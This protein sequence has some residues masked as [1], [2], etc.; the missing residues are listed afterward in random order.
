MLRSPG[1]RRWFIALFIL[2]L[3]LAWDGISIPWGWL[4]QT[5]TDWGVTIPVS[6]ARFNPNSTKPALFIVICKL[7]ICFLIVKFIDSTLQARVSGEVKKETSS[8]E[9]ERKKRVAAELLEVITKH[10]G[11][12]FTSSKGIAGQ[13]ARSQDYAEEM[14]AS[15]QNADKVFLTSAT[16]YEAIGKSRALLYDELRKNTK[17]EIRILVV[18]PVKGIEA[19]KDRAKELNGKSSAAD[20][21]DEIHKTKGKV[22]SLRSSRKPQHGQVSIRYQKNLPCFRVLL[23]SGKAF[24]SAYQPGK[25]GH[26]G[27]VL[28]FEKPSDTNGVKES[29]YSAYEHLFN[30]MWESADKSLTDPT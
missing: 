24:V 15:V 6:I 11:I 22:D 13:S 10:A 7:G 27:A 28:V 8:I 21:A 14:R 30:L 26:E 2:G 4:Q 9:E 23:S 5:L 3:F 16:A 12:A 17:A 18:H 25:D 1:Y 19:L 29:F 20:L